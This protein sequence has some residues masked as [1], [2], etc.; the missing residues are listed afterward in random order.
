MHKQQFQFKIEAIKDFEFFRG[1]YFPK[2]WR[3][4]KLLFW[5]FAIEVPITITILTLT[6]VA[7]HNTYRTLLWED[8]YKNGFNSAPN[9]NLYAAANYEPYTAPLVWS[10]FLTNFN[11][12]IGVLSVFL[13]IVKIPVHFM[14]LFFPPLA[15]FVHGGCIVVYAFAA[16]YQAGS[17][18][19]DP[20]QPQPGAP[21]YITKSCSVAY[22]KSDIG[23]CNQAKA[24][25]ALCILIIL[26]Y[27]VEFCFSVR[28]C[29][30]T[31]KERDQIIETREDKRVEKEFEEEIMKSPYYPTTPGLV[32]RTPGFPPQVAQPP[33][34]GGQGGVY[35]FT[36][37][38][39]AFNRLGSEASDL[40][41]R[42]NG[43]SSAPS[44]Q[45]THQPSPDGSQS[46]M[47]FPPPPKK[48]SK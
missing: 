13:L 9:Q 46:Q 35:P 10:S 39:L 3:D 38:H 15:T 2:Q 23:F 31:R 8:G 27:F 28:S 14:H 32:P 47:Y 36:P 30:I 7:S 37:R 43:S 1:W 26:I 24:L 33:G 44:P 5:L 34:F 25:F 16:R 21:W 18:M 17:D 48:A 4:R 42:E 11:L 20:S 19:S 6:G 40:P 29:F 22:S 41:L 45:T 12:V